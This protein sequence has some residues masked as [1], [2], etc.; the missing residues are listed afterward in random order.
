MHRAALI[1]LAVLLGVLPG[2]LLLNWMEPPRDG[3][4]A[5]RWR[6]WADDRL[7]R[8]YKSSAWEIAIEPMTP[9]IS[10]QD[11][12]CLRAGVDPVRHHRVSLDAAA[13]QLLQLGPSRLGGSRHDRGGISVRAEPMAGRPWQP[14]HV[15]SAELTGHV[16]RAAGLRQFHH[17]PAAVSLGL[18]GPHYWS[19][20]CKPAFPTRKTRPIS[21]ALLGATLGMCVMASANH[22]HDGLHRHRNGELAKLRAGRVS[23][24][25]T[26][27]QRG[28]V[29]ICRLW[30]RRRGRHALWH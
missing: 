3:V 25:T 12:L 20:R 27:I 23:Q 29:E 21:R 2:M 11:L 5:I 14:T 19:C 17:L 16:R 4:G 9:N 6:S 8:S 13:V 26:A 1:V 10:A 24:G 7:P 22:L 18:H 15:A 30:R 28:G